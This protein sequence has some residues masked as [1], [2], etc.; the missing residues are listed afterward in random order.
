MGAEDT[1]YLKKTPTIFRFG[2]SRK[3]CKQGCWGYYFLKTPPLNFSFFY[4]TPSNSRQSKAQPLD[5]TQNCIRS[6]SKDQKQRPQEIPHYFLLV[7]FGN[8]TLFLINPW[9]F[10]MLF[11]WY[12][13]KCHILKLPCLDFFW[14]SPFVTLYHWKFKTKWSFTQG[15]STNLCYTHWNFH[16]QKPRPME[17]PQYFLLITPRNSTSFLLTPEISTFYHFNTPGNSMPSIP[18]VWNF[19]GIAQYMYTL[20]RSPI[21]F[22]EHLITVVIAL[23]GTTATPQKF[24][25]TSWRHE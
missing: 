4:F 20:Y 25:I 5:I 7:I 17:I 2:Y 10:H 22:Y 14:N 6:K 11:L 19:S 16:G 21:T 18:P 15:N 12:P 24:C 9:K 3:K 1:L 8:S 13:W 23:L